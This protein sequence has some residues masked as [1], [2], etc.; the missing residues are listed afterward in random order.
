MRNTLLYTILFVF[1]FVFSFVLSILGLSIIYKCNS[2][3]RNGQ[4]RNEEDKHKDKGQQ[5]WFWLS[6]CLTTILIIAAFTCIELFKGNNTPENSSVF[7]KNVIFYSLISLLL[8]NAISGSC[9]WDLTS[10]CDGESLKSDI[11][12]L[13]KREL[14]IISTILSFGFLIV[15][16]CN[17]P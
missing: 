5:I 14:F 16:V 4:S 13:Q 15:V 8:L 6:L 1:S 7:S 12:H 10:R 2:N 9:G 11:S 17:Q 3:Q